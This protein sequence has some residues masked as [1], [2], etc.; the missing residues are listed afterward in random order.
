M[1]VEQP[2]GFFYIFGRETENYL[3]KLTFYGEDRLRG[4]DKLITIIHYASF[5]DNNEAADSV[6]W[7]PYRTWYVR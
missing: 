7:D 4:G 5:Q 3:E 1:D 6:E 2:Y